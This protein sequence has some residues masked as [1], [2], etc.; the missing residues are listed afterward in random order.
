VLAF[1]ASFL[2]IASALSSIATAQPAAPAASAPIPGSAPGGR[3][4]NGAGRGGFGAP[5]VPAGPPAPVPPEVAIPRP[6]TAELAQINQALQQFV[7]SDHSALKPVLEKYQS[8]LVIQPPRANSAIAPVARNAA[9]HANFVETAKKGDIDLLLDGDSITDWWIAQ[10]GTPTDAYTKYFGN[11]KTANFAVAGE[12]TEQILWG[13]QNGEGQ[14]FQPK[15]IMLMIG[16]N[17]AANTAPEVAEGIGAIVLEMRKDFP[18]AKILLLGIFPRSD[19]GDPVRA[20]IAEVNKIIA[21]LDDHQ[22]VFYMDIGS[23]FLDDKGVFL[24]DA[25]RPDKLHPQ[26]KGY[27]IWGE[28]VKDTLADMLK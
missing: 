27:E 24:P 10:N 26:E 3:V 21:K 17:N 14:G 16:T 25:F 9:R 13:L 15:A 4:G 18:N 12:R 22:H 2:L 20:K 28:A 11:I 23:K 8:L 1:A 5:A 7:A 6:T 19:P